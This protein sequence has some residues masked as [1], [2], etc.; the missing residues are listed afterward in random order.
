MNTEQ[1]NAIP[2][3]DILATLGY[4]PTRQSGI[5]LY[6]IS[7]LRDERTA[8]FHVN[9]ARN[10]WF[11]H[12]EGIGGTAVDFVIEYL[13]RQGEYH[14]VADAL[15][16]L[17]NMKPSAKS[18]IPVKSEDNAPALE[19][20]GETGIEHARLVEYT[21]SRGISLTLARKYMREIHV[22]N[23]RTG[24]TIQALGLE[25]VNGGYELRNNLFKGSLA[26]KTISFFR[27][28]TL[29]PNVLH[30]FE[31]GFD[32]MSALMY[33][34]LTQ[35][36]GDTIVLNGVGNLKLAAPYIRNY[37]YKILHSWMDND[38]AGEMATVSLKTIALQDGISFEPM[39]A[40]YIE[41]KD[42]NAWHMTR[43]FL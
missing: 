24:K 43:F 13:K 15:R 23:K 31:G 9:T 18:F 4:F 17:D 7:P 38:P 5:N 20:V 19:L 34:K 28:S 26:P 39:N 8:S 14:T 32:Y 36:E 1:A 37:D 10:V 41:H 42:V 12:G 3:S 40:L 35:L 11:D 29:M 33:Y 2:M 22:L 16:W 25:N 27:G 6:Y 21:A 30:V